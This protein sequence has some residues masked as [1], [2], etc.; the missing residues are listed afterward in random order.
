M[1]NEYN[2]A[3]AGLRLL[4]KPSEIRSLPYQG[5]VI[6]IDGQAVAIGADGET[7]TNV[8][9][10]STDFGVIVFHHIGKS[11]RTED[12]KAEAYVKFDVPPVMTQGR[13]WVKPNEKITAR[14]KD[15]KVYVNT[16]DGTL[17]QTAEGAT[18]WVGA[19]W[20]VLTNNDG[21]AVVNLG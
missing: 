19:Y 17:G 5:D 14:G 13:V 11:G 18:E 4:S 10:D 16:T 2:V 8:S 21:L 20:D 3:T 9:E 6:A 1:K 15:A 12:G 7:C